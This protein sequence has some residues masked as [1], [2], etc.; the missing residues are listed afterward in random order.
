[1]ENNRLQVGNIAARTAFQIIFTIASV[2][3]CVILILDSFEKYYYNA[4]QETLAETTEIIA[5]QMS[6][7]IDYDTL[8]QEDAEKQEFVSARY[9]EFLDSFFAGDDIERAAALY[10]VSGE[11]VTLLSKT[12]AFD[13]SL[14]EDK[15]DLILTSLGSGG[16]YSSDTVRERLIF[17]SAGTGGAASETGSGQSIAAALVSIEGVN[18]SVVLI[19]S[20]QQKSSLA[21]SGTIRNRLIVFAVVCSIAILIYFACSGIITERNKRSSQGII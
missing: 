6:L 16:I 7:E 19:V 10:S 13:E 4:S 11:A 21:Y 8:F 2:F 9:A 5:A 3:F 17:S 18:G 12:S 1:M 20:S 14:I 15:E